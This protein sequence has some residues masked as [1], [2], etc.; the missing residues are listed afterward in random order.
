MEPV[1]T[2]IRNN[3]IAVSSAKELAK[4]YGH[5]LQKSVSADSH[6]PDI[7]ET[8]QNFLHD[9]VYA[10]DPKYFAG[11]RALIKSFHDVNRSSWLEDFLVR[12][13]DPI[14]WRSMKCAN[15]TVRSQASQLFLDVFPLQKQS[16]KPEE[17]DAIIQ[18]QFD[19]LAQ[20]L[21]DADHKVRAIA[22][23]GVCTI[24]REYWDA[25]PISTIQTLL[26]YICDTLAVDTSSVLVRLA[27]ISGIHD[28]LSQPLSHSMMK[29]LL[30][31]LSQSVYDKSDRVRLE[32]IKILITV[33]GLREIHFY[34]IVSVDTL[35]MRLVHERHSTEI[36]GELTSLL[37]NSFFPPSEEGSTINKEHVKRCLN[38]IDQNLSA[39]EVFY[40]QLHLHLPTGAIA[41]FVAMLSNILDTTAEALQASAGQLGPQCEVG[42]ASKNS[43]RSRSGKAIKEVRFSIEMAR[44]TP[45]HACSLQANGHQSQSDVA[46]LADKVFGIARVLVG[47]FRGSFDSFCDEQPSLELLHKFITPERLSRVVDAVTSFNFDFDSLG[48]VFEIVGYVSK[49]PHCPH[50]QSWGET[51]NYALFEHVLQ[52]ACEATPRVQEVELWLANKAVDVLVANGSDVTILDNLLVTVS[53][54]GSGK[55]SE[56][57]PVSTMLLQAYGHYIAKNINNFMRP[58]E[59]VGSSSATF[60]IACDKETLTSFCVSRRSCRN[61]CNCKGSISRCGKS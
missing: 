53:A 27:A 61:W 8:I 58:S 54:I 57:L 44:H 13:F 21:K 38:M 59:Q 55:G 15:A 7:E 23:R 42:P 50:S 26:K 29:N 3:L 10:A 22:T 28:I 35:F 14:I 5:L 34:D 49:L 43:K 11:L 2:I 46:E 12:I 30:P 24:L 47:I 52:V 19:Q 56:S 39:A 45:S 1:A 6:S 37:F 40:S 33:K 48:A 60:V 18:K 4:I 51:F 36:V 25:L 41:K 17:C 20:L 31:L 32:F 9:A 16:S